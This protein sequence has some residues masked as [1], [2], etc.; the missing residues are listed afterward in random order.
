MIAVMLA[1]GGLRA[2]LLCVASS[3]MSRQRRLAS[4][5]HGCNGR[6]VR[7]SRGLSLSSNT[8]NSKTK[9]V[10]ASVCKTLASSSSA[11]HS[12]RMRHLLSTRR[13]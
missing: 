2:A 6:L 5:A 10:V 13:R 12:S 1:R 8:Q 11:L 4:L 9:S 7:V 3:A